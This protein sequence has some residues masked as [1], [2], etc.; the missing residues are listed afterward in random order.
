MRLI[1]AVSQSVSDADLYIGIFYFIFFF[2]KRDE[3]GCWRE[4]T[5]ETRQ[6]KVK[7]RVAFSER[8]SMVAASA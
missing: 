1:L 7:G 8:L 4:S 5:E 2:F 6:E 3:F